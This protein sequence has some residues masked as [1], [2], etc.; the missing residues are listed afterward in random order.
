MAEVLLDSFIDS[1][2]ILAVVAVC[3]YI[4]AAIEPFLAKKIRLHGK[5]A[6]L[7]GVSVALLPQC[8]FSV[9]A[10]DLYQKR[11]LT[12]GTLMGV[13]IA[14]S[15][16]ALPIFLSYPEKALH[17]LPLIA[18]KFAIGLVLGYSIDLILTKSRRAVAHHLEHC[19]DDYQ[20]KLMHC[21]SAELVVKEQLSS[22]CNCD[23]C[24]HSDCPHIKDEFSKPQKYGI[25]YDYSVLFDK[26]RDKR[27]KID[28]FF[29]RPLL[30]S[31][32]IFIYVLIVNIIFGIIIYYIGEDKIIDF[33]L[34]NKYIAP[35]ISVLIGAVPNCVSSIVLSELYIMGGLGFGAALGGLCMNAGLGFMILFKNAK[36]LK[37]N[38]LIFLS[39]LF[40]SVCISY[41]FSAIFSFGSLNI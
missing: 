34:L 28:R 39:M 1:L 30:H 8:G 31:L 24:A 40:I 38:I 9:V 15:D 21:D 22:P 32:E 3:T 11:H 19:A 20:I 18:L 13:F 17:V 41:I 16:E 14:T 33:L 23:E 5:L 36:H 35:L 26:K 29:I 10:A 2:K 37:R 12:I 6:P 7:I 27:K 25:L 4:V